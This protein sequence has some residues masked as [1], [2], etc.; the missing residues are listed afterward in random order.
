M[1]AWLLRTGFRRW[2]SYYIFFSLF[3]SINA[4][5]TFKF[6]NNKIKY[7]DMNENHLLLL[8]SMKKQMK[9]TDWIWRVFK[10]Y[11]IFTL[12]PSHRLRIWFKPIDIS[13]ARSQHTCFVQRFVK[14]KL[15]ELYLS[16][17]M[18]IIYVIHI[19]RNKYDK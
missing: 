17:T 19:C 14:S 16:F 15:I 1:Y 9:W 3:N 12:K 18:N 4:L 7:V 8:K 2:H 6:N 10:V 5:F 11:S 13:E